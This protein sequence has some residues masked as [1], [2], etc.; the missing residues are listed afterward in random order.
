MKSAYCRLVVLF[1]LFVGTACADSNINL[2]T[3]N[4]TCGEG[5][6][7]L[8]VKSTASDIVKYCKMAVVKPEL[9]SFHKN[10]DVLF[11]SDNSGYMQC[12]FKHGTLKK[13]KQH[14]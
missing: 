6:Y 3:K 7:T 10:I 12:V 2:K 13:C 11:M 8:S 1:V 4:V 9:E 5:A 14:N